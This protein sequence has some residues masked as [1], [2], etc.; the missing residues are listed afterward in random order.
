MFLHLF[1]FKS[2]RFSQLP[3]SDGRLVRP[4]HLLIETSTRFD[5]L[6]MDFGSSFTALHSLHNDNNR[7]KA[8]CEFEIGMK[9]Q[10]YIQMKKRIDF[11]MYII[12]YR[13]SNTFKF[14]SFPISDGKD[15]N[16]LHLSRFNISRE[17]KLEN[18]DGKTFNTLF[19][20]P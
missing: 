2:S 4:T 5:R 6:P 20:D 7:K 9:H 3:I 8:M 15:S 17:V 16:S 14:I 18:V 13:I 19:P 12:T 1:I 11:I 10:N